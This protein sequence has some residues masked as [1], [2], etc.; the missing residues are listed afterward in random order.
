MV[1][2]EE[3]DHV[4]VGCDLK[5]LGVIGM[6][7]VSSLN[8]Q[9]WQFTKYLKIWE[10]R[11]AKKEERN[12]QN[13]CHSL[14]RGS[15]IIIP[16]VRGTVSLKIGTHCQTTALTFQGCPPMSLYFPNAKLYTKVTPIPKC[17]SGN[18]YHVFYKLELLCLLYPIW[19]GVAIQNLSAPPLPML[20]HVVS[21]NS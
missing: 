21:L 8:Q 19:Q 18:E 13:T 20:F 17:V 16:G 7:A 10:N 6:A 9:K 15:Y 1:R 3:T 4:G 11:T 5:R 2:P 14:K 12:S